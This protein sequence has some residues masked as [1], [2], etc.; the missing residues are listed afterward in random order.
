MSG[1]LRK[2]AEA[3]ARPKL[4]KPTLQKFS[5]FERIAKQQEWPRNV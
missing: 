3:A 5:T 2:E 4:P 1:I